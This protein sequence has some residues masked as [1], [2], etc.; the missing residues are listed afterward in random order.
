MT[1]KLILLR[2]GQSEWNEKNLFTGWYD[3]TLTEKGRAEAKRGGELL[4]ETGNLPDIL[5]TSLLTRAIVT[6]NIALEAADHVWI[7]VKRSWRLNERH[8]GALQGKNKAEVLEQFGEEQFMT[9][10]RSYDTPPPEL[11]DDSPFSQA[12]DPRYADLVSMPRTEC[13]EQVLERLLPYWTEQIVPDLKAEKTVLVT[14]HGNSLRALVKHLDGISDED[15]AKLNIPTGI[16]LVYELDENLKPVNPGGTYLDPD[17]AAAEI[18]NVANQ[19][20]K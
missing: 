5:H 16:P 14:A 18:A 20:K 15:I 12:N 10:R 1:Y 8:Y 9:W 3:V 7:P 13:L 2:H 6:S 17:A 4:K 19:G 11:D